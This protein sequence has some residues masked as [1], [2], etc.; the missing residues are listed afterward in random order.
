MCV[1][2]QLSVCGDP[3]DLLGP[4]AGDAGDLQFSWPIT[5]GWPHPWG[6]FR[7]LPQPD[8]SQEKGPSVHYGSDSE[9]TTSFIRCTTGTWVCDS[10]S[11]R[12]WRWWWLWW[13]PLLSVGCPTIF[14]SFWAR[15]TETFINSI[16]FS[17]LATTHL[18]YSLYPWRFLLFT[19]LLFLCQV[20]LTIFWLAMS[21]TMYNP[22]IYCCL[23]QRYKNIQT[24]LPASTI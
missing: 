7:S 16:T 15:L 24:H 1:L 18:F 2:V 14:T 12:W 6:G 11:C 21:S 22:I 10:S 19:Q 4:S 8:N 9:K 23:N 3:P 17:R 5:V 13:W 20:Y